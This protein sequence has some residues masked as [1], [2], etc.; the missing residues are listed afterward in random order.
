MRLG[1]VLTG[2][3]ARAAYQVG[4]LRGLAE[5]LGPLRSH[6]IDSGVVSGISAGAINAAFLCAHGGGL[7]SASRALQ[8]LWTLLRAEKVIRT[9]AFSLTGM[10]LRW[11]FNL[12]SG[13]IFRRSQSTH[14]LDTEPLRDLLAEH[15]SFSSLRANLKQGLKQ[16][17]IAGVAVSATNYSTGTAVTFF[18]GDPHIE[19]WSRSSRIG[20]RQPLTL[21]HV[22][23]S[24]SIPILFKPVRIGQAFFGDGGIRL[25]APLSPAFH[26]GADKVI[27]IGIRHAASPQHTVNRNR[28]AQMS[29]IALADIGGVLLDSLMLDATDS[30]VE[31]AQRINQTV[32][33]IEEENRKHHPSQLRIIPVLYLRPSQDLGQVASQRYRSFPRVLRYF[34]RGMGATDDRSWNFMSYMAFDRA[35]TEPVI[36]LG[37]RD[38]L[39]K[40]EEILRFM[41]S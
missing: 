36:E 40:Q 17:G 8:D 32:T 5:V 7:D 37:Y 1:L 11:I 19:P 38:T 28:E 39:S 6:A 24:A 35:Y 26:M 29:S 27:A 20:I 18:D 34:L 33:L 9:G 25:S 30:D 13:G 16:G 4:V 12:S 22:L 41:D 14:L 3:G 31:R 15:I 2:G 10:G 21:D 23:A